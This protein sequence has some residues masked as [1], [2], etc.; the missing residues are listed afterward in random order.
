MEKTLEDIN[1]GDFFL[2]RTPIAQEIGAKID[3]Y[4]W[5]KLKGFCTYTTFFLSI[6]QL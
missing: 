1:I 2:N 3:K 5:S 4:G 6:H